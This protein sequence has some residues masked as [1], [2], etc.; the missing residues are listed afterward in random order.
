ML[1]QFRLRFTVLGARTERFA[2]SSSVSGRQLGADIF[3]GGMSVHVHGGKQVVNEDVHYCDPVHAHSPDSFTGAIMLE[4]T[5]VML[6]P[7]PLSL[8]LCRLN[9][10]DA[11]LIGRPL[12][13]SCVGK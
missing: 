8:R 9:G 2:G 5:L 6:L 7:L 1:F 13:A 10:S 12:L 11:V 4:A 3:T